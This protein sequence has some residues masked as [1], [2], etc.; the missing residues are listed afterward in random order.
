MLLCPAD[1]QRG[2]RFV[3]FGGGSDD[4]AALIDNQRAR[5]A[6]SDVNAEGMN[7][8]LLATSALCES[9]LYGKC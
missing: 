3:L 4:R 1:F 9:A 6:R 2:E 8:R 7:V 5:S